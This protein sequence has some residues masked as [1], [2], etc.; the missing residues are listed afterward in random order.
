MTAWEMQNVSQAENTVNSEKSEATPKPRLFAAGAIRKFFREAI[1]VLTAKPVPNPR[2]RKEDMGSLFKLGFAILHT[3]R[4]RRALFHAA[5]K[6]FRRIVRPRNDP[7][8]FAWDFMP[9]Y[10]HAEHLRRL[11]HVAHERGQEAANTVLNYTEREHL[12]PRL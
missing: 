7:A 3:S 6:A 2:R 4:N 9:D 12:S 8:N 10:Q 5:K 11:D 1:K